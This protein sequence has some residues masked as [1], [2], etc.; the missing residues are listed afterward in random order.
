M[1]S[2]RKWRTARRT[3]SWRCSAKPAATPAPRLAWAP[4]RGAWRWEWTRVSKSVTS[5]SAGLVPGGA[6]TGAD[7]WTARAN[8]GGVPEPHPFTPYEFF[9]ALEQSGSASAVTGWQPAHL[10][11]PGPPPSASAHDG[12]G[13]RSTDQVRRAEG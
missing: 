11:V 7:R 9:A 8:P 1:T 6:E 12:G 4:C 10:L 3:C 13:A 2:S 5:P